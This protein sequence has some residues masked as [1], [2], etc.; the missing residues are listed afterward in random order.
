MASR[1]GLTRAALAAALCLGA[2]LR[3]WALS[4]GLPAIFNP[5]EIPI[6]SR[7]LALAKGDLN[8]HN[9]LYPTL[10]FYELF[11][12]ESMYFVVGRAIGLYRSVADFQNAFFVD[13]S[14]LVLV[15]RAL[16]AVFGIATIAA[17]YDAGRRLY[18]RRVGI[19]AALFLA[20]AP[21]AVRDAHYVKLDVPTAF[22]V[23][24]TYAALA[25]L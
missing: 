4:Y 9:F 23:T 22:F 1:R 15:G 7:A 18:D 13:P 10:Y 24:L 16:T 5:D 25:R 20:V 19:G 14:R 17:V 8:P 11:A 6:L 12:W 3:F 2:A 21:F